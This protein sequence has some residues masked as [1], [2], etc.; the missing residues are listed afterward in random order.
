MRK[1]IGRATM[2]DTSPNRPPPTKGNQAT[3]L[4]FPVFASLVLV[5][6]S[7]LALPVIKGLTVVDVRLN[8][9]SGLAFGHWGWCVRSANATLK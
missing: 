2:I 9:A 6:I 3:Y 7:N 4:F 1:T 5:L 8:E